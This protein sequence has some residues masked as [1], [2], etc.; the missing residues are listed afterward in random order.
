MSC[1]MHFYIAVYSMKHDIG[2][3]DDFPNKRRRIDAY[4]PVNMAV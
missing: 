4:Y 1:I 3:P 2:V